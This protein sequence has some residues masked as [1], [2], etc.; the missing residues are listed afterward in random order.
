M[1]CLDNPWNKTRQTLSCP[2]S[3]EPN[4]YQNQPV[5]IYP[6]AAEPTDIS[7]SDARHQLFKGTVFLKVDRTIWY[8]ALEWQ[9]LYSQLFEVYS[10]FM[11]HAGEEAKFRK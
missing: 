9:Q 2:A 10:Y 11:L 8:T 4:T 1:I 7:S 5:V 3:N 6:F